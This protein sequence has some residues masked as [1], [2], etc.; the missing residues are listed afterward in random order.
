VR[1]PEPTTVSCRSAQEGCAS[2]SIV[3][4]SLLSLGTSRYGVTERAE[5]RAKNPYE[6]HHHNVW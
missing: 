6:S 3:K 4:S 2:S 5:R 1:R